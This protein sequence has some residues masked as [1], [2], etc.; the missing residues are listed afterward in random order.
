MPIDIKK[1]TDE[2]IGRGV[3]Y[4]PRHGAV[5]QGVITSYND[6]FIF[7]NYGAACMG[8]GL[9]TSPGDLDWLIAL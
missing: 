8:R 3:V 6:S 4:K 7:V 2:H 9:A 5:E 1:V